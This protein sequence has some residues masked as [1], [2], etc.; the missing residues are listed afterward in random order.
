MPIH[1]ICHE[2][3][4]AKRHIAGKYRQPRD[5]HSQR[6]EAGECANPQ[7][8]L[9]RWFVFAVRN[10]VG[11]TRLTRSSPAP[12]NPLIN[13]ARAARVQTVAGRLPP[14]MLFRCSITPSRRNAPPNNHG[15]QRKSRA[16]LSINPGNRQEG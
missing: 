16:V 14:A 1:S 8:M 11:G 2:M 3:K 5:D 13:S 15:N 6:S 4:K 12:T 7:R 9:H 10:F